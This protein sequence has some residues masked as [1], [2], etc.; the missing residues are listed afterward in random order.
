VLNRKL[1]KLTKII[2]KDV[3]QEKADAQSEISFINQEDKVVP[4]VLD[5]AE[6]LSDEDTAVKLYGEEARRNTRN[7]N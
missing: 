3:P 1:L 7:P 2:F 5:G 4:Q 6:K